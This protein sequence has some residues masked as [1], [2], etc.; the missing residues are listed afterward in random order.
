M[1]WLM[2]ATHVPP[3]G[4]RGGMVR[5]AVETA[6]ALAERDDIELGV[7][8]DA[9][10]TDFWSRAMPT[11][12]E[13]LGLRGLPV[14]GHAPIER[15]GVGWPRVSAPFDVIH[16]T[17]HILPSRM[18][19]FAHRDT[20]RVLTVHDFLPLDRPGDF[21]PAK[22]V[23]LPGPYL[24]SIAD[25]DHIFCI[26]HATR[27]RL[28]AYAPDSVARSHVVPLAWG[29]SLLQARPEPVPALIGRRFALVV[30]DS[31]PRKNL[32]LVLNGMPDVRKRVPDAHL[33]VVGPPSWGPQSLDGSSDPGVLMLG[34]LSDEQLAWCY[35]HAVVALCPSLLEGFGLPAA[36]ALA[37]GTPVITSEDP[38]LCEVTGGASRHIWS[39][40]P[41]MWIE[42]IVEAFDKEQRT[43]PK[44]ARSWADVVAD[45]VEVVLDGR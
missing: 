30:G 14:V 11:G 33:A 13:V 35:R 41:R 31:S 45:M 9:H 38:A 40:D 6:K 43:A 39:R 7:L 44:R 27:D 4:S 24:R 23:L 34:H 36:E 26:S 29:G 5:Y 16:G 22:Q 32:P 42:A 1:R 37:L 15:M 10:A 12:V 3:G 2:I 17:K 19:G 21:G 8:A 25:S 20:L 18:A 28:L